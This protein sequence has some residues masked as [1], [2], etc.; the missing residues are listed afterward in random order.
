MMS[1]NL[2]MDERF[3]RRIN[4][5]IESRKEKQ[6]SERIIRSAKKQRPQ[7]FTLTDGT[8]I[9]LFVLNLLMI[10]DFN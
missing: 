6:F 5:A 9:Y 1:W 3:P 2:W 7:P 10:T 8:N 4:S